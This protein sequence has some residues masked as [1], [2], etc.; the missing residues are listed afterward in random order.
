MYYTIK[1]KTT[2]LFTIQLSDD[3]RNIYEKSLIHIIKH[4]CYNVDTNE[5]TFNAEN[6]S[7][8]Q[9]FIKQINYKMDLNLCCNMI[10][11]LYKQ[12]TLLLK[13]GYTFFGFNLE[14]IIIIDN[15]QFIYIGPIY[16]FNK[17]YVTL[18]EPIN[19]PYFSSPEIIELTYLPAKIHIKSFIYSLGV[20]SIFCLKKEYILKGNDI[21]TDNKLDS[22]LKKCCNGQNK[23][24]WF[25]SRCLKID[26]NSRCCLLI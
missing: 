14:D 13:N 9:I 16:P 23:L 1:Q 15:D 5:C 20:L 26:P 12:Y 10:S 4:S 3:L 18:Y 21:L 17:D 11:S 19:I 6:V 22:V 7:N 24:Y 25:L 8:L 2:Y